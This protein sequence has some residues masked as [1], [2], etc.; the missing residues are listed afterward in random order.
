ML[1]NIVTGH[2]VPATSQKNIIYL[3]CKLSEIIRDDFHWCF[4]DGNAAKHISKFFNSIEYLDQLDWHS[5]FTNDF[6]DENTDGDEDRIRKKHAE[7]LVKNKVSIDYINGI[8]VFDQTKKEQVE[9]LLKKFNLN[10]EVKIKPK[11]YFL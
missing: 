9:A 8:A 7:F 4:T 2:G 1:Y 5:I 11:F 10:I 3:C 6:R